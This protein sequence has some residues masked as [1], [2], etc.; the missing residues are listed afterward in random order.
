MGETARP[1]RRVSCASGHSENA[2]AHHRRSRDGASRTSSAKNGD[3]RRRG[4]RSLRR[5]RSRAPGQASGSRRG[6]GEALNPSLATTHLHVRRRTRQARHGLAE[7]HGTTGQ[8][9][10]PAS[11]ASLPA[12]ASDLHRR[13]RRHPLRGER[14]HTEGS[15]QWDR[16][17]VA[18][19]PSAIR[20]SHRPE[21]RTRVRGEQRHDGEPNCFGRESSRRHCSEPRDE[22]HV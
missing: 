4:R 18:R 20:H 10:R 22:W 12:H 17:N 3:R 14:H 15:S 1:F 13:V 9:L 11:Q 21:R 8:L 5:I 2:R 6:R 16:R 7:G 19:R